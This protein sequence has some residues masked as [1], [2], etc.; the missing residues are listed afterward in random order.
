MHLSTTVENYAF[1]ISL[2]CSCLG[3]WRYHENGLIFHHRRE[4]RGRTCFH[5]LVEVYVKDNNPG[6]LFKI[7]W[8][9]NDK[10]RIRLQYI[11][12]AWNCWWNMF[13]NQVVGAYFWE[14]ENLEV[15]YNDTYNVYKDMSINH[16][17]L[18][19][20]CLVFALFFHPSLNEFAGL[21]AEWLL[22][23]QSSCPL[24]RLFWTGDLPNSETLSILQFLEKCDFRAV[25]RSALCRARREF[26]NAYSLFTCKI[27]LRYSRE[28]AL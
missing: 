13:F 1:N 11:F 9:G 25:Q 18:I 4:P 2:K 15:R 14:A 6:I 7:A 5:A 27:W 28:R 12:R 24:A 17:Y 21:S 3:I 19:G 8:S 22:V 23:F 20:G 26:S 16:A 10:L